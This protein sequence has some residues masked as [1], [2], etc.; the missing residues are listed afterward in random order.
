MLLKYK[1]NCFAMI[2]LYTHISKNKSAREMVSEDMKLFWW[3][4][5]L[6]CCLNLCVLA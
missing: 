6:N 5:N 4:K 3:S 2:L 1:L